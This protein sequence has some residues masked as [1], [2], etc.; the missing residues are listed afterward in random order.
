[1]PSQAGKESQQFGLRIAP[2]QFGGVRGEPTVMNGTVDRF[3]VLLDR[4]GKVPTVDHAVNPTSG[5]V[6]VAQV[7]YA[8][9]LVEDLV[10]QSSDHVRV[11]AHLSLPP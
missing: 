10:D 9:D 2:T 5:D 4:A 11:H 6:V 7:R 1:M 8:I 3:R